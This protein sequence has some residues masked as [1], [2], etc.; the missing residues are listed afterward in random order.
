[1]L[2]VHLSIYLSVYLMV[3]AQTLQGHAAIQSKV[4]HFIIIKWHP[5]CNILL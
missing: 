4:L 5:K 1:M 2:N 3:G